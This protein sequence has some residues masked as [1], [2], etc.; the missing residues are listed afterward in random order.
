MR[1]LCVQ[2]VNG[3]D[4]FIL[5]N[6]TFSHLSGDT[7]D[8]SRHIYFHSVAL[9]ILDIFFYSGFLLDPAETFQYHIFPQQSKI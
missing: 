5:A 9:V 6:N 2:T 8:F 4:N 7:V 1:T 3:T